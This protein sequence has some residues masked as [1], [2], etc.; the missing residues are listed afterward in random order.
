MIIDIE[1]RELRIGDEILFPI[2]VFNVLVH[3]DK[4]VIYLE[5]EGP[6]RTQF[7]NQKLELHPDRYL[8]VK[9]PRRK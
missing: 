3:E 1:A 8:I 5:N 9:A 4:V 2:K 6:L 7:K